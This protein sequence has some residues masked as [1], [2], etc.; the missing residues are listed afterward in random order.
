[1]IFTAGPDKT[2]S[3]TTEMRNNIHRDNQVRMICTTTQ[4]P[5]PN[6]LT[7]T[8]D[9]EEIKTKSFLSNSLVYEIRNVNCSDMGTYF[10]RAENQDGQIH[11]ATTDLG[12]TDCE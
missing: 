6:T 3:F 11:E 8:D 7:V 1:M 5:E 10:C 9:I 4:C 12:V 2:V